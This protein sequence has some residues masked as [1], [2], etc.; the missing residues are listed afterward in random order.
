[1]HDVS[2]AKEQLLQTK[3]TS[4]SSAKVYVEKDKRSRI[5]K[6]GR[7]RSKRDNK[8]SKHTYEQNVEN[9][10]FEDKYRDKGNNNVNTLCSRV[11]P[12]YNISGKSIGFLHFKRPK[13]GVSSRY[14]AK[15]IDTAEALK[16]KN[17]IIKKTN[18]QESSKKRD[19]EV[20]EDVPSWCKNLEE[21][22]KC[23]TRDY[24]EQLT[25]NPHNIELWLQYIEFQ[26]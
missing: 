14:Y 9:V 21:E 8:R 15:N 23:K 7:K 4:L 3:E 24:N 17:T 26:V 10:Y 11:R 12:F 5:R 13:K 1:M 6:T 16:K 22:Q 19:E 2:S 25:A 18:V 20:N